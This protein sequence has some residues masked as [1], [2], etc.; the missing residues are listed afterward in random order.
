MKKGYMMESDSMNTKVTNSD[1]MQVMNLVEEMWMVMTKDLMKDSRME[2]AMASE[3]M[4]EKQE[5][6]LLPEARVE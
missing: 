4:K 6:E 3:M 1:L 2:T 5:E